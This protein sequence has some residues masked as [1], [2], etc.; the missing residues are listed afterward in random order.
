MSVF[1]YE[2]KNDLVKATQISD[3]AL[4]ESLQLID[5]LGEEEFKDAKNIIELLKENISSWKEA[6]E[7]SK[8]PIDEIE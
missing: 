5:S 7:E 6:E 4:Q 2:V 3:L 1:H 8:R